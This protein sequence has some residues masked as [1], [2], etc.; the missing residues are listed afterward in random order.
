MSTK[1]NGRR[2]KEKGDEPNDVLSKHRKDEISCA[3]A[4]CEHSVRNHSWKSKTKTKYTSSKNPQ[5][6]KSK[7]RYPI[8]KKV[9]ENSL[10]VKQV[11]CT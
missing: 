7:V 5:L 9:T 6:H 3:I 8:G 11:H 1:Q 10:K 4:G 2:G